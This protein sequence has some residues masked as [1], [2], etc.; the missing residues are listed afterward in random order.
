V[1]IV[2]VVVIMV[3]NKGFSGGPTYAMDLILC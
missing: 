1:M 3:P 2:D